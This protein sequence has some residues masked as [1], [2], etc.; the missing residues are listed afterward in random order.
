[1]RFVSNFMAKQFNLSTDINYLKSIQYWMIMIP[2]VVLIYLGYSIYFTILG[3]FPMVWLNCASIALLVYAYDRI[4]RGDTRRP[5]LIIFIESVTVS[6][7]ATAL[8]GPHVGFQALLV[9]PL[10]A[11]FLFLNLTKIEKIMFTVMLIILMDLSYFFA[12]IIPP[13]FPQDGNVLLHIINMNVII[14]TTIV[15]MMLN[16]ISTYALDKLQ[17]ENMKKFENLSYIDALTTLRNRRYADV[18]FSRITSGKNANAVYFFALIDIDHF[19]VINDTHGHQTGDAVL[20]VLSQTLLKSVRQTDLVCRWGGEEFLVVICE[21][22]PKAGYAV[23]ENMRK[24]VERISCTSE[25][26]EVINF[27]ITAGGSPLLENNIS[28]TI[29]ACDKKLY[30][31]KRFGRNRVVV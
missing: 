25:T 1:M 16:A 9:L 4:R 17:E 31:G 6:L 14:L 18:F 7:A 8:M 26:G 3:I 2:L 22:P 12:E 19:K 15:M 24:S 27:T 28:L 11:Q 21:C 13:A 30:K 10:I 20:K 23:L 5:S 29:E